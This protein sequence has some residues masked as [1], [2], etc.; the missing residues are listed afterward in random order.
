MIVSRV[1]SAGD[2]LLSVDGGRSFLGPMELRFVIHGFFDDSG[3]ES[4]TGNR[5]VCM[6]GYLA[7]DQVWEAFSAAWGHALLQYGISWLHMKDFMSDQGEYAKW[8]WPAKLK[9]LETFTNI[10]KLSHLIGFGVVL[11]ADAWRDVPREVRE[12]SAQEFCFI[13]IIK[14]VIA[15]MKIARPRD[16]VA[17]HFDCD[18]TFAP[19]RFQRF[20]WARDKEPEGR[21]YLQTFCISEP[22]QFL[23]LQ[24]ADLLAWETRKHLIRTIAGHDARPEFKLLLQTPVL[25]GTEYESEVWDKAKIDE[26][27]KGYKE[28]KEKP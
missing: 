16:F 18:K 8:D 13:R 1:S 20:L 17:V 6:A 5:I 26:F 24:A 15:R 19:A 23:P 27:F 21:Y 4:D 12:V 10:I 7:I 22:R 3:Q 9:M 28:I 11:D 14:A 2:W 25:S